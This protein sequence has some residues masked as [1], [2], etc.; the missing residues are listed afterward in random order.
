MSSSVIGHPPSSSSAWNTIK[1]LAVCADRD[2]CLSLEGI[3]E[4]GECQVDN[5]TSCEE[6]VRFLQSNGPFL[7]MCEQSLPDGSWKDLIRSVRSLENPP[8]VIVM[9]WHADEALWAE[10]LNLGGYDVLMKPFDAQEVSRVT[11]MA[12]LHWQHQGKSRAFSVRS[13]A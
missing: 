12:W 2:D 13:V 11:R 9:S 3:L 8:P 10:V 4:P 1:L 7:I 5:V 6:A